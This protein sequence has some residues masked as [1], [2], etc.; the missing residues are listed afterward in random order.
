[1]YS[2]QLAH[3]YGSGTVRVRYG[4]IVGPG[5]GIGTRPTTRRE[6]S[7]RRHAALDHPG[8]GGG[9]GVGSPGLKPNSPGVGSSCLGGGPTAYRE[10]CATAPS[11][12]A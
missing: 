7:E 8:E 1:V 6:L 5:G 2:A 4:Y 9:Q 11:V 12:R 3:N 10:A